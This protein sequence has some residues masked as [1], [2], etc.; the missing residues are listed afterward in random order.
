MA[1]LNERPR[2]SVIVCTYNRGPYL[3]RCLDSLFHQQPCDF[4]TVVVNGP[5]TDNT[6]D[7]L[8]SYPAIKVVKQERLA[9]IGHARNLGVRAASAD[10]VAFLDDDAVA[11]DGWL[12][13]LLRRLESAGDIGG[14]GGTVLSIGTDEVQFANGTVDVY[15]RSKPIQPG[16]QPHFVPDGAVFNNIIGMNSAYRKEAINR[17]EGFD[18]YFS[19]YY[20]ET[21]LCVRVILAG[22]KVVHEPA[23]VIWHEFAS[24]HNRKSPWEQNWYVIYRNTVYFSLKN[25]GARFGLYG[26]AIR[27]LLS[28]AKSLAAY[29]VPFFRGEIAPPLLFRIY[30]DTIR[31]YLDGVKDGRAL[32]THH[33]GKHV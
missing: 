28:C 27:P 9:G 25:F 16:P 26:R 5:S 22:Y 8:A 30:R 24:G 19:Y 11:A 23:A 14:V 29:I 13:A 2:I 21:D 12:Q 4:E 20:E 6:E 17:V 15:G 1:D 33:I 31:G 18:E 32:L 7:V 3:K 10:L